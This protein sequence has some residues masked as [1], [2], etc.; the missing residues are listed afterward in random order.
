ME[1]IVQTRQ[2]KLTEEGGQELE[3]Q[4]R[5]AVGPDT[6]GQE[7]PLVFSSARVS[8]RERPEVMGGGE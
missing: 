3:R 7:G 8:C 2:R 5:G 1:G 6:V 4:D